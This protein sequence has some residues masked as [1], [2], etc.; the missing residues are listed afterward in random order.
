MGLRIEE[1]ISLERFEEIAGQALSNKTI[2]E[3]VENTLLSQAVD[4]IKAT[5]QGRLLLNSIT[6]KLLVS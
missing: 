2:Q 6:E 5:S 4:R 3:L 1:G